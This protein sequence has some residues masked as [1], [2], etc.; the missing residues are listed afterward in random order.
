MGLVEI[1]LDLNEFLDTLIR[2][3]GSMVYVI[4]FMVVFC[5]MGLLPLFFL[6]G[7]PLLFFSGAFCAMGALNIW[8][9]LPLLFIAAVM[10]SL[11]NYWLGRMLGHEAYTRNYRWLD[12]DA[13]HKAHVF[14]E[15]YGSI[16]FLVSPYIAVVRTF[17]PF[18]GGVSNMTA[19]K[20][21]LAMTAGAALWVTTLVI[22]G[23]F[24]GNIPFIRDHI[25][26]II[27]LG[28]CLGLGS[29]AVNTLLR[30]Y[31]AINSRH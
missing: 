12:R 24:F 17:A 23:Y 31:R 13:L 22:G 27:L 14:Y 20:F 8:L 15:R 1:V 26:A 7:D 29:L 9:L 21:M 25:G 10:G 5:E 3:H 4:L 30:R 11:L 16:T 6:P 2:Q 28:L 19:S 18:V